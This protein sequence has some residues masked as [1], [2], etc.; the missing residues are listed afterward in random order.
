MIRVVL[1]LAAWISISLANTNQAIGL[2]RVA[3]IRISFQEDSNPGTT[4][5]GSFLY[6]APID[7]CGKY[8]IDPVP[9]DR[10]YFESQLLAVSNYFKSVSYNKFGIDM[11]N[12]MV[13]P[14][15]EEGSYILSNQMNYYHPFNQ[16]E[17]HDERITEL[18]RDAID[19]SLIHI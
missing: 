3:A 14:I 6:S 12:S 18:F 11:D 19:L 9:H 7:T 4:G 1:V 16:E 15:S 2:V 13:Y 8:T 5:N 10:S 17:I